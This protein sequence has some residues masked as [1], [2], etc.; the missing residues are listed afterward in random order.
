MRFPSERQQFSTDYSIFVR[1]NHN[2]VTF[3]NI[4]IASKHDGVF[5][6]TSGNVAAN[7]VACWLDVAGKGSNMRDEDFLVAGGGSKA[8][9]AGGGIKM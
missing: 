1:P 5:A 9:Y 7:L 2:P 8:V 6:E 3:L 4:Q